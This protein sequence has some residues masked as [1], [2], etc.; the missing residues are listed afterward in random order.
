M[1]IVETFSDY[2]PDEWFDRAGLRIG[3]AIRTSSSAVKRMRRWKHSVKGA[4]VAVAVSASLAL[5]SVSLVQAAVAS[6]GDELPAP[7]EIVRVAPPP[8]AD[9]T[10]G[11]VNSSFAELFVAFRK[12]VSLIT[13]ERTRALATKAAARRGDR[14]VDW[15][16]K[17][18]RDSGNADD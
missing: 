3:G 13:N 16:R 6:N 14:P 15:A 4:S 8:E 18:A 9:A 2:I 11:E 5:G 10:L 12:G 17:L 7:P 1:T